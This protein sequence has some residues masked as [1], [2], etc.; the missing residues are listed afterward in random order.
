[1]TAVD[2]NDVDA[3]IE[4]WTDAYFLRTREIVAKFGDIQV[5]YA[6]YIV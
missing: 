2:A 3:F 6:I 1:M 5:T 4:D